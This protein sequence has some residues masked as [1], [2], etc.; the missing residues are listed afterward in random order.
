MTEITW[1]EEL[2]TLCYE[3][4]TCGRIF[5]SDDILFAKHAAIL[6]KEVICPRCGTIHIKYNRNLIKISGLK[7]QHIKHCMDG[8]W[9]WVCPICGDWLAP[10]NMDIHYGEDGA[11]RVLQSKGAASRHLMT[12]SPDLVKHGRSIV[13]ITS[14]NQ[15]FCNKCESVVLTKKSVGYSSYLKIDWKP[16]HKYMCLNCAKS[17]NLEL[18]LK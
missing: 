4:K 8:N 13:E 5:N 9:Y 1:Q 17:E 16:E 14:K 18:G 15:Y 2:D 11:W 6:R 7:L 10:H 12:H 3:C